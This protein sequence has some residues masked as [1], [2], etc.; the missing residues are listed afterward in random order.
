[1][2]AI[3]T[4]I[5]P[6]VPFSYSTFLPIFWMYKLTFFICSCTVIIILYIVTYLWVFFYHMFSCC[7]PHFPLYFYTYF[8][9]PV[10]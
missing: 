3:I 5:I 1:M 4:V 2:S 7:I 6:W 8:L 9:V 10:C